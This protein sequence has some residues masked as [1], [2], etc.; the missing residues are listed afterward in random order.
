[1]AG[2]SERLELARWPLGR[3]SARQEEAADRFLKKSMG[4]SFIALQTFSIWEQR[5]SFHRAKTGLPE[6]FFQSNVLFICN[7]WRCGEWQF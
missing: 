4:L 7:P 3:E 2:R 6:N 1:M 5:T